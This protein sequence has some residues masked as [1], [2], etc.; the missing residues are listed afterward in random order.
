M[1]IQKSPH[2]YQNYGTIQKAS[3][4]SRKLN[5]RS[6]RK[7]Y[8]TEKSTKDTI[9]NGQRKLLLTEI[10]FFLQEYHKLDNRKKICVYIGASTGHDKS[11]HTYTL[12]QM[13]P[14]FTFHLYDIHTFYHKLYEL[15]NVQI[16]QRYFTDKDSIQYKGKNVFMISDMRDLDIG[17][18]KNKENIGKQNS[19]VQGDMKMQMKFYQDMKPKSALLKFRLPW[20]PGK[21]TYLDG[22][23]YYQVWQGKHSAETRLVPN[24]KMKVYDNT[25]YEER[26]FYFNTETRFRYYPHNYIC[27]GHCYDCMSEISILEQYVLFHKKKCTKKD[28]CSLAQMITK[29]LSFYTD[30]KIFHTKLSKYTI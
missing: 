2:I 29:E 30:R 25:S 20:L 8:Y 21:T 15:P 18:A 13:F 22:D 17:N 7:K 14:E 12:A 23:I 5:P 26:L 27:Y 16:F 28:V 3:S 10:E 19:I 9:H 11:L 1:D 6:R 4:F 24:G